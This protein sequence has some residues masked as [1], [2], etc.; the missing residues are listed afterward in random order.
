MKRRRSKGRSA[1]SAGGQALQGTLNDFFVQQALLD[2]TAEEG[3]ARLKT[4]FYGKTLENFDQLQGKAQETFD[5]M[6]RIALAS[7][8]SMVASGKS[9]FEAITASGP[10]SIT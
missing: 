3:D 2:R 8:N 7:F 1:R 6:S 4:F 9:V 5:R 10:P